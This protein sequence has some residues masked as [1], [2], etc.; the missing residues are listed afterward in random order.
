MNSNIPDK[1]KSYIALVKDNYTRDVK[2]LPLIWAAFF[3]IYW[4]KY[5]DIQEVA[6]LSVAFRVAIGL[7]V[8][9]LP[10]NA[11]IGALYTYIQVR[12]PRYIRREKEY[13]CWKEKQARKSRGQTDEHTK[14]SANDR[15]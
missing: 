5:G 4:L 1:E 6:S 12:D 7:A 11:L 15:D 13:E 10:L 3:I 9:V 2:F 14:Q 8:V